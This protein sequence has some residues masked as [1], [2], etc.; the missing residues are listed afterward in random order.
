MAE[1]FSYSKK[2]KDFNKPIDFKESEIRYCGY[3][4]QTQ[5]DQ[6]YSY[7]K[8]DPNFILLDNIIE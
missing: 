2:R 5:N 1:F 4:P 7:V 6:K 8:R 3:S